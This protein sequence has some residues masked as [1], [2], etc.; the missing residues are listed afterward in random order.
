MNKAKRCS[1]T[2]SS[3]FTTSHYLTTSTPFDNNFLSGGNQE[4][5]ENIKVLGIND[6]VIDGQQIHQESN[7]HLISTHQQEHDQYVLQLGNQFNQ[8]TIH[9]SRDNEHSSSYGSQSQVYQEVGHGQDIGEV[10]HSEERVIS[11]SESSSS[12]DQGHGYVGK[13][14]NDSFTSLHGNQLNQNGLQIV[15]IQNL[16]TQVNQDLPI[17]KG[18]SNSQTIQQNLNGGIQT[19]LGISRCDNDGSYK[20]HETDCEQ[21]YHCH[22]GIWQ[23]KKCG[24]ETQFNTLMNICDWPEN[25]AK[26]RDDCSSDGTF[27]YTKNLVN[28]DE[29]DD[30]ENIL[31]IEPSTSPPEPCETE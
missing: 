20:P 19:T 6:Q 22:H 14:Q 17:N 23:L 3:D 26:V 2:T 30:D 29:D 28:E 21:F 27:D 1:N 18:I 16:G 15:S 31:I 5:Q 7:E 9:S 11:A 24:P 8:Q 13:D 4:T 12:V 10:S 25:V